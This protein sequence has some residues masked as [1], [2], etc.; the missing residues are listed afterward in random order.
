[1]S[2]RERIKAKRIALKWTQS[3]LAKR[4]NV[5]QQTIS[6]IEKGR[7]APSEATLI[8]LAKAFHCSVDD[9]LDDG[10]IKKPAAESDG[11]REEIINLM[12]DLPNEDVKQLRDYAAW[13]KS[14][15]GKE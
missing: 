13:L 4:S 6:G 5:S 11:L 12:I 3:E 9:L 1:M 7:S 10:S 2:S 8:L 14:R 15:R